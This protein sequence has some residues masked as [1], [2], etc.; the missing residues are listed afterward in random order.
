MTLATVA[1]TTSQPQARASRSHPL[2]TPPSPPFRPPSQISHRPLLVAIPS[3]P[4]IQQQSAPRP[5]PMTPGIS[6]LTTSFGAT[7]TKSTARGS[8][9]VPRATASSCTPLHL[10][11]TTMVLRVSLWYVV[12]LW[13]GSVV[14]R[15]SGAPLHPQVRHTV[16]SK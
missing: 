14:H 3:H 4:P 15:W 9:L 6:S 11:G 5:T 13:R 12:M 8:C 2:S 10:C 16:V 7:G 1:S